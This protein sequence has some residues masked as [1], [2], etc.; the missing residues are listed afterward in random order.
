MGKMLLKTLMILLLGGFALPAF[1]QTAL[2]TAATAVG[3]PGAAS[4]VHIEVK[5]S[6]TQ[7]LFGERVELRVT[8]KY[9]SGYRVF[10]PTKPD[11]R[12]LLVDTRDPG[13]VDRTE[14]AGIITETI[15]IPA[16]AVRVGLAKTPPIEVPW[17]AGGQDGQAGTLTV[18]PS[19][20]QVK[21]Q[22]AS[23]TNVQP[24]PLP[25]PR[26]LVEENTPVEIALAVAALM[27]L[28]ALLTAI[29]LKYYRDRAARHT[30]K[31]KVP[32][33]LTALR[34]LAEFEKSGRAETTEPRE[35][36]A[37]LSEILR[38]Y[39]GARYH[40][41]ALD[42]TT[43]ELLAQ[44]Q[45]IAVRG[46]EPGE[47]QSFA[48]LSDLVKFA[49]VPATGEELR[50]EAAFVR[51]VVERSML[52]ALEQEE[53]RRAEAERLARQKRLRLAVM[54][55]APL[56]LRAFA[57]DLFVGALLGALLGWVAI[58]TASKLLFDLSYLLILAWLLVRDVLAAQSPGKAIVGLQIAQHDDGATE[59]P[60]RWHHDAD[61]DVP[62][63]QLASIG[64]RLGRNLLLLLPLA[65]LT[66]EAVTCLY[67]PEMRRMG[68][69]WAATRVIDARYG[70]RR[71]KPGW[72]PAILLLILAGLLMV[73]PM[74]LG[75]RP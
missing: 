72:V 9:P 69:Q 54:A 15:V 52:T 42:M 66:A 29:G 8:L 27:L 55:P 38:E 24:S 19:R 67:L 22:F 32:P 40:F 44:L 34:R 71:G 16:L 20:L 51:K 13:K 68:D 56:R 33:H 45:A 63:A 12:P 41:A 26:P 62:T 18:P 30:P 36:F 31:E 46:V 49:R 17:Q 23:D 2:P 10:F 1:A 5:W 57:I 58:D 61:D 39:L 47:L 28:A 3:L 74:L 65:G 11:L 35:V 37:E 59:Q 48:E 75:G 7:P 60:V 43:T 73:M 64:A 70:V 21:S 14:A 53:Q 6:N 25:Q 50:N 4:P